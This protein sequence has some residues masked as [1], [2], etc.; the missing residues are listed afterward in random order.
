[1]I[2]GSGSFPG[3]GHGNSL[4]YSC[5]ENPHGQKSLVG[6]SPWG[7]KESDMIEQVSTH[8]HFT[9]HWALQLVLVVKKSD[10]AEHTRDLG[11]VPMSERS[12]GVGNGTP[13]QHSR[14]ENMFNC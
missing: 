3:G 13:F 2:L 6:C 4:Q 7:H 1:M 11:S 10:N 9:G 5:L 12:P 14:L 8:T